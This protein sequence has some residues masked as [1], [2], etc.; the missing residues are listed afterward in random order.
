MG[1]KTV[2]S[3]RGRERCPSCHAPLTEV[4]ASTP[5]PSGGGEVVA[6]VCRACGWTDAAPRLRVVK[7]R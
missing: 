5:H 3:R 2:R 6:R 4:L 7:G 1:L